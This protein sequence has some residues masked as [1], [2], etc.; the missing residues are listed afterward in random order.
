LRTLR[1][2]ESGGELAWFRAEL[3]RSILKPRAFARELV[4]EHWG[5]EGVIA[6]LLAGIGFSIGLDAVVILAKGISPVGF[7]GR[8]LVEGFL[9]GIRLDITAAVLA[10]ILFGALR[11][12]RRDVTID[13]SFT[14]VAFALTPLI[15]TP[16]A[17][18]PAL[19][20]AGLLLVSGLMLGAIVL[21]V[22][23]GLG[24]NLRSILPLPFAAVAL[25][26]LLVSGTA[27]LNDQVSRLRMTGYTMAPSL[28]PRLTAAPA[29]GKRY[30]VEGMGS[31][32][33]PADW[34][35]SV[36]G[37]A[38]EVAHFETA[39]ATLNVVRGRVEPLNTLD[40][41]ADDLARG[42]RL[43]FNAGRDERTIVRI[44]DALAVAD[45]ADGTYER[46]HIALSQFALEQGASGFA[47]Q[48][49]FFDPP[50]PDAAFAQAASIAV[51]VSAR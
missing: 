27:V 4:R 28:A 12:L 32:V 47:L 22:L 36:R 2:V 40:R 20:D 16:I 5:L 14:A 49:R 23:V 46:R 3:L 19:L 17:A 35:F 50:D 13:Q 24:L 11:L 45:R 48:F 31:L 15:V 33:V 18:I 9:L 6:A 42:E 29:Q 41:F 10:V 30:D 8:I 37:I 26:V 1:P 43:G 44:G 25:L 51:T 34:T 39:T 38:G 7:L 21:R